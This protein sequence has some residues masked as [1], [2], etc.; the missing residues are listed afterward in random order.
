MNDLTVRL[1]SL[2]KQVGDGN[3]A[4]RADAI[5]MLRALGAQTLFPLLIPMLSDSNLDVRCRSAL[6]ILFVD[7]D[8]GM[9]FVVPLL[10]DENPTVRWYVAGSL[11]SSGSLR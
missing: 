2:M 10:N 5:E 1:Q 4:I 6:C 8:A 7:R 3:W 11:G 9:E